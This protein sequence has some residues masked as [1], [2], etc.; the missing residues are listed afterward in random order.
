[1]SA[2]TGCWTLTLANL[3]HH[4]NDPAADT[5][6]WEREDAEAIIGILAVLISHRK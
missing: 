3:A 5:S 6:R 2:S 4:P 1:M